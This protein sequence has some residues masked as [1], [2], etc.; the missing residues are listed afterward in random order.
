MLSWSLHDQLVYL[1]IIE[2]I[3]VAPSFSSGILELWRQRKLWD[4]DIH[5]DNHVHYNIY[6]SSLE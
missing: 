5:S 4:V 1:Q 3:S 6:L 2:I